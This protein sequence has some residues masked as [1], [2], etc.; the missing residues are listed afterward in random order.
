MTPVVELTEPPLTLFSDL[1]TFSKAEVE[2]VNWYRRT[3]TR[4][5]NW[6]SWVRDAFSGLL[7]VPKGTCLRISQS[8]DIGSE[9]KREYVFDKE[10]IQ[11]GRSN[12]NDIALPLTA[13]S[14]RHA[15]IVRK[16]SEYYIE[17]LGSP[18]GTYLSDRR[19]NAHQPRL[20]SDGDRVLI[21][22]YTFLVAVEEI[23]V[24]DEQLQLSQ[25]FVTGAD[26]SKFNLSIPPEFAL[27][28]VEVHPN[29]GEAF[30]GLSRAFLQ[31]IVSRMTREV[32]TELASS[33]SG[34]FEF[35]LTA[36]LERA[37]RELKFPYQLL[38][39]PFTAPKADTGSGLALE[40]A[41]GI[42]GATGPFKVFLARTTVLRMRNEF[43]PPARP[44]MNRPVVW[45]LPICAGYANLAASDL[46]AI[47][48]GDILLYTP[49]TE[50]LLPRQPGKGAAERGWQATQVS[51]QPYRLQLSKFFERSLFMAESL[52]TEKRDGPAPKPDLDSLPVRIHVVLSDVE[53]ILSE[54]DGLVEGSILELNRSK[55]DPVRLVVNGKPLGVGEL[56]E[57]EG[58]LGVQITTWSAHE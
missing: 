54:L 48:R 34:I 38:L 47:A 13:V 14:R 55:G 46:G 15:R 39:K 29:A 17:D 49:T 2:L 16:G 10:E 19:L 37:N 20:L 4:A 23:W 31:T 53:M 1:R 5:S 27:F 35:L 41:I 57:I 25:T 50:V 8:D 40:F 30:I 45:T 58:K 3:F 12:E 43:A 52:E 21:F 32:A 51:E 33:D 26:W 6:E 7:E 22:P 11:I 42:S 24:P 9:Q 28:G 36:A 18:T 56:I 44:S